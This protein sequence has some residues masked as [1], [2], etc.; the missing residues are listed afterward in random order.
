MRVPFPGL[1]L[2]G[3]AYPVGVGARQRW[4]ADGT[5]YTDS[6]PS[7]VGGEDLGH[8]VCSW[9]GVQAFGPAGAARRAQRSPMLSM[10]DAGE[11]AVSP[12]S[13]N[14]AVPVGA[15]RA[16]IQLGKG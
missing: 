16:A 10:R 1:C 11:V 8:D 14:S 13:A 4:H 12:A 3:L 9:R 15:G 2:S 5:T 6:A 7:V